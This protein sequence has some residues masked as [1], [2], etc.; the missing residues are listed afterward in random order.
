M[1]GPGRKFHHH[2]V[3]GRGDA[4]LDETNIA[5]DKRLVTSNIVEGTAVPSGRVTRAREAPRVRFE[6]K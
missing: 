2:P 4:A 1:H 3:K 6:I 5:G